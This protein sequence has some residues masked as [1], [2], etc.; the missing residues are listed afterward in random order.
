[1]FQENGPSMH[2]NMS[3]NI[4]ELSAFITYSPLLYLFSS[5]LALGCCAGFVSRGAVQVGHY[6][7]A[8]E[9]ALLILH[10]IA[11]KFACPYSTADDESDPILLEHQTNIL[12][13]TQISTP[14]SPNAKMHPL[15]ICL[16]TKSLFP[17]GPCHNN[18]HPSQY[19]WVPANCCRIIWT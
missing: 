17:Q 1:M 5:V 11:S 18:R 3:V 7:L 12:K 2:L 6:H 15:P 8:M 19:Y 9:Q 13:A 16:D 10:W 4:L 14:L